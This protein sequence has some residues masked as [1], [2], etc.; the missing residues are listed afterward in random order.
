[1]SE[2]NESI[3]DAVAEVGST[4]SVL[5]LFDPKLDADKIDP[6][7]K[8][9]QEAGLN[10]LAGSWPFA[11]ED[12]ANDAFAQIQ[13]S[14]AGDSA[15][16]ILWEYRRLFVGPIAKAAPPWGSVYTDKECAIFG[17]ATLAF[18][19]WAREVGVA[20]SNEPGE[21]EDH[22][23]IMLALMAWIA[24]NRPELLEDYLRLHLLTWAPHFADIVISESK[25]GLYRGV[26]MLTKSTLL[27][28]QEALE[29]EV[30]IPKF[31]R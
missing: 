23:G 24:Q 25:L 15:D 2:I 12:I 18:R 21:P 1:M 14:L 17:E 13:V 31:Y 22:I 9:L 6:V 7:F 19:Q 16:D 29:L 20:I 26:G 30:K 3:L 28:I 5:Y 27:G 11:D 4:L 10:D 8:I